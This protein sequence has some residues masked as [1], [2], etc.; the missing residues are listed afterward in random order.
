MKLV[1][2][3][4]GRSQDEVHIQEDECQ[5]ADTQEE[6]DSQVGPSKEGQTRESSSPQPG[7]GSKFLCMVT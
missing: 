4:M 5:G 7:G 6:R 2:I 1:V 3:C